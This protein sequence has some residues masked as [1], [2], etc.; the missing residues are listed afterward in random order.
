LTADD[1]DDEG[2]ARK[3]V[4]CCSPISPNYAA[5]HGSGEPEREKINYPIGIDKTESKSLLIFIA[6]RAKPSER[7]SR[8]QKA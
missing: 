5:T 8:E 7:D 6:N 3:K 2:F 4:D 1:N